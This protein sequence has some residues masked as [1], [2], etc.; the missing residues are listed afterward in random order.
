MTVHLAA[1]LNHKQADP[2]NVFSFFEKAELKAIQT[3]TR[4]R[5]CSDPQTFPPPCDVNLFFG[6]FFDGTNNNYRRDEKDHTHSNVARL[7]QA[8]QERKHP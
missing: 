6:L 4:N 3:T 8:L 7:F 5:E 2:S 1:T